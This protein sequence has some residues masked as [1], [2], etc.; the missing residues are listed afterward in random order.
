MLETKD[1]I[2]EK[3]IKKIIANLE[4]Q[5]IEKTIEFIRKMTKNYSEVLGYSEYEILVATESKR[6]YS[7]LY[8]YQLSKF[9]ILNENVK[10]FGNIAELLESTKE[11]K[12]ICPACNQQ[13]SNPYTCE[14]GHVDRGFRFT[15]KDTFLESPMIDDCFLPVSFKE[16]IYDLN[17]ETNEAN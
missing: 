16:S 12:F 6:T 17:R 11:N 15:I 8:Y 5:D 7:P 3:L 14:K 1:L 4:K 9:P 2:Y 13:Q 10:I